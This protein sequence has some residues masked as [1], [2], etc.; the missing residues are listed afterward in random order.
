MLSSYGRTKVLTILL[1]TG[2]L[3]ISE[4]TRR[5]GLSHGAAS[6]HLE[7]LVRSGILTEKRFNRIR[8]FRVDTT[9][10]LAGALSRFYADWK[11][12][13]GSAESLLFS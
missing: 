11:D 13:G 1:E 5:S 12:V 6:R 7:F 2:E 10:P 8:I 4:I 3:N 9:S